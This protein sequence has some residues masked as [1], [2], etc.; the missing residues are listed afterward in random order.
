MTARAQPATVKCDR[1]R[2]DVY[3]SALDDPK[4][5]VDPLC[6]LRREF[7]RDAERKEADNKFSALYQPKI[8]RAYPITQHPLQ[9]DSHIINYRAW[10]RSWASY[11]NIP[12]WEAGKVR[13]AIRAKFGE[14]A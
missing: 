4:R 1:C 5:C 9:Q 2:V 10:L 3:L 12:R 11:F 6:S 7:A 14:A 13:A 8:G